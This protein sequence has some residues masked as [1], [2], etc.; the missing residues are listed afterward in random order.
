MRVCVCVCVCEIE[1]EGAGVTE[2]EEQEC[3]RGAERGRWALRTQLM[4]SVS[5]VCIGFSA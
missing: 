2:A 4:C 5:S 1:R 3:Q